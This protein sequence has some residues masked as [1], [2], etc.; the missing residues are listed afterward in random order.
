MLLKTQ[1]TRTL[2][3]CNPKAAMPMRRLEELNSGQLS[4]NVAPQSGTG[5]TACAQ[6]VPLASRL[7]TGTATMRPSRIALNANVRPRKPRPT[8]PVRS[9]KRTKDEGYSQDVVENTGSL[10][11]IFGAGDHLSSPTPSFRPGLSA[12]A[13]RERVGN[14]PEFLR[15]S[16]TAWPFESSSPGARFES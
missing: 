8:E 11:I 6:L 2:T 12:T 9:Q 1:N 15:R 16:V 5:R 7:R 4:R 14:A 10:C 3:G 13:E